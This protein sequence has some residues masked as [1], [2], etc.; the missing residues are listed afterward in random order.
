M[1]ARS[2]RAGVVLALLCLCCL[3]SCVTASLWEDHCQCGAGWTEAD[4]TWRALL[5]PLALLA[6]ALIISAYVCCH[7]GGHCR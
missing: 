1:S 6:D 4:I 3:P 7:G 2:V 5:T